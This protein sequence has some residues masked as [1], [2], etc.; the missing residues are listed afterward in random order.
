MIKWPSKKTL[1]WNIWFYKHRYHYSA[2]MVTPMKS[3][4]C[5]SHSNNLLWWRHIII[6]LQ[7]IHC[8]HRHIDYYNIFPI[9]FNTVPYNMIRC[10]NIWIFVWAERQELK[11]L[12][13]VY[14]DSDLGPFSLRLIQLAN[15]F[16][17]PGNFIINLAAASASLSLNF[18][19]R[20][21]WQ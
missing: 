9:L 13:Q 14:L 18:C 2:L 1:R 17:N 16:A 10:K 3:A 5:L 20:F 19:N 15:N 4:T 6:S 11:S 7:C 21:R 12:T 8:T